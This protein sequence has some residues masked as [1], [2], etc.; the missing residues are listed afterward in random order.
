MWLKSVCCQSQ[1]LFSVYKPL[2]DE[3]YRDLETSVAFHP[4]EWGF[5]WEMA[6]NGHLCLFWLFLKCACFSSGKMSLFLCI[7]VEAAFNSRVW[8]GIVCVRPQG[9]WHRLEQSWDRSG[10]AVRR[11][12]TQWKPLWVGHDP[13]P[14]SFAC[15]CKAH[16]DETEEEEDLMNNSTGRQDSCPGAASP[17]LAVHPSNFTS[18]Y[19][20]FPVYRM[21]TYSPT[22]RGCKARSVCRAVLRPFSERHC[23]F[24]TV[25]ANPRCSASLSWQMKYLTRTNG[26]VAKLH[27]GPRPAPRRQRLS[28]LSQGE[29]WADGAAGDRAAAVR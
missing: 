17:W 16:W 25:A 28:H 14:G 23:D 11:F 4:W 21:G 6:R 19:L 29:G 20:S 8:L 22:S 7:S 5:H 3:G 13:T 9:T 1:S 2:R 15:V 18:L 10:N 24:H 27:L 26:L 12:T